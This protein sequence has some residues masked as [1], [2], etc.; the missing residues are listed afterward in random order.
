[1]AERAFLTEHAGVDIAWKKPDS[2][3]ERAEAVAGSSAGHCGRSSSP[4]TIVSP[5]GAPDIAASLVGELGRW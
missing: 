2:D 5:G 4:D 1:M 3:R